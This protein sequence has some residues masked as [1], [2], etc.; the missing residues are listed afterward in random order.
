[1]GFGPFYHA[2]VLNCGTGFKSNQ[3]VAGYSHNTCATIA[4][5]GFLVKAVIIVACRVPECA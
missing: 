3:E 4:A 5:V 1:M 2:G